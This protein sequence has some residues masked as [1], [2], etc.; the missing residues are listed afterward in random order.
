L[1]RERNFSNGNFYTNNLINCLFDISYIPRNYNYWYFKYKSSWKPPIH[2][3]RTNRTVVRDQD[4]VKVSSKRFDR[5]LNLFPFLP[6]F[7]L[8]L[9]IR[10]QGCV[11]RT[12]YQRYYIILY[13]L[14]Y[15]QWTIKVEWHNSADSQLPE[16][17]PRLT[18][19]IFV[20]LPQCIW[21]SM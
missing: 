1:I 9:I 17:S 19:T 18:H 12:R 11:W 4:K 14:C 5:Y 13:L 6:P 20:L 7:S 16:R 21:I 3:F 15:V 2:G 8:P 10:Y